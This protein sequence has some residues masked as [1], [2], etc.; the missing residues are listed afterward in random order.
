V[1]SI[2]L[3]NNLMI[4]PIG[5]GTWKLSQS[6]A[7]EAV[8]SALQTGYRLIDTAK[9]YG[10]EEQVGDGIIASGIP[11]ED[12]FITTKLWN[13][14]Q[15]YD[16]A[17]RAFDTSLKKLQLDYLDL[18]LMH[19]P[20]IQRLDSWK[21]MEQ[22]YKDGRVKAIGVCNFTVRH[23]EELLD[24]TEIVPVVNQIEFHPFLYEEQKPVLEF[25]KQRGITLEAYS[26]LAHAARI[27][28]ERLSQIA[29]HHKK[30]N[31]QIMLRW[32]IQK[33]TIPIPKSANQPRIVENFDIFNFELH[34]DEMRAIDNLSDGTRTCGD[35]NEME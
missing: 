9:I 18:Y 12:I 8:K 26:P 5:F 3:N 4:P 24:K 29:D 21:A 30:T 25:C 27:H 22:L 19:W 35:P 7:C 17:L 31:A 14:D 15:G 20:V 10:N 13:S 2:K 28:D 16:S 33:G 11:R 32:A 1:D 34:A 23:L 6:Q